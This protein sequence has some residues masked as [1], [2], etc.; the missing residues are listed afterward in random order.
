MTNEAENRFV[1]IETKLA[2]QE[3][4]IQELNNIVYQQQQKLDQLE[5]FVQQL[6]SR[7]KA[8]SGISSSNDDPASEVPPHY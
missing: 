2:F 6:H 4:T 1:E 5:F 7:V 3:D 8:D